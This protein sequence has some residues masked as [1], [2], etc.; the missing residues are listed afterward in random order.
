MS[1]PTSRVSF[2]RRT[3]L[4]AGAGMAGILA[5]GRAPA[6]AASPAKKLV[7]AHINAIPNRPRSRLTGW[8]R[9]RPRSRKAR[10]TCSS[11]ARP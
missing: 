10:L 8:R 6:F 5:T 2:N 1:A 9:K 3:L 11:S 7:F 4:R